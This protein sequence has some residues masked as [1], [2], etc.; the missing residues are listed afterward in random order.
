MD[1]RSDH[2]N[3][4]GRLDKRGRPGRWRDRVEDLQKMLNQ[5]KTLEQIGDY[6]KVSRQRMYQVMEKYGIQTPIRK[7]KSFLRDKPPRYSWFNKMLSQKGFSRKDRLHLLETYPLPLRCPV[8]GMVLNYDGSG[9]EGFTR[10]EDSPSIDRINSDLPY[11]INNICVISW[12]ANRIKNDGT[13]E[14]HLKIYNYF[15]SLTK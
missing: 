7:N 5:G 10:G 1:K 12:R 3:F 11:K 13:P 2:E 14:E 4:T 6:Y 8:L 15:I 9:R